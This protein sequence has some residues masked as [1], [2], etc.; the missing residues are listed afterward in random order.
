MRYPISRSHS[1]TYLDLS[2]EYHFATLLSDCL[3][4]VLVLS[5]HGGVQVQSECLRV[6]GLSLFHIVP[7]AV[8][9][10]DFVSLQNQVM[11]FSKPKV[12]QQPTAFV[13]RTI[14][15]KLSAASRVWA[16]YAPR[17]EYHA[18]TK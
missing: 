10:E 6:L 4:F 11:L 8:H 5:C 17:Y 2:L 16:C 9:L 13:L 12:Q 18:E 15:R 14:E 3:V 7:K 1:W